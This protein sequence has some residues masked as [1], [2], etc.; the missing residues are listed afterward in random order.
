MIHHQH[1]HNTSLVFLSVFIAIFSSYISLDL[2]NSLALSKGR[3]RLIWLSGGSLAMGIGIWSMHFVAMLAFSLPSITIAY[4]VPLLVLSILVAIG[5]SALTLIIVSGDTISIK[6]YIL[7][8]LTMGAAIAGMHYIGIASMRMAANIHWDMTYVYISILIAVVASF[9]ALLLAFKL[10]N[11]TSRQG[12]FFR[13]AGGIIMG[14]AISGM[15]YTAMQAMSFTPSAVELVKDDQLLATTGLAVVV[16]IGTIVILTIALTGSIIDRALSRRIAI[17]QDLE[18]T[19][20]SRDE[21]L[22]IVSHELKTPLTTMKFQIQLSLR[23][24]LSIQ[25][26]DE[27]KQTKLQK[28]LEQ[29]DQS[30]ARINRLVDDMLDISR[31][32]TGK[33]A[34]QLEEFNLDEMVAEVVERLSPILGPIEFNKLEAVR[35]KWDKFRIEQVITNL[36]T[37]AAKY[38]DKKTIHVSVI[39]SSELA[40][41]SIKDS[42]RGIAVEDQ[43]KIFQRFQR[44]EATDQISGLGIGLFVAKEIV[45]MHKGSIEVNSELNHGAEFIVKIPLSV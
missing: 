18:D 39:K 24:L 31:I 30:I 40:I 21:F 10:R 12:T 38:G 15:H 23:T 22:S 29:T 13:L 7:G 32:S 43:E 14:F 4:D 6:T 11:E 1:H 35:G 16:I 27:T 9:V 20:K 36:L 5:A 28:M 19:V 44:I 34:L 2:A 17:S 26:I 8:S 41:V 3:A 25:P 45:Q 33:L 42:G 37:N